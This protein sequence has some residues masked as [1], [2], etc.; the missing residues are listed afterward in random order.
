MAEQKIH[1][2]IPILSSQEPSSMRMIMTL[3]VAGFFSGLI[4]VC[5][6]VFTLP[7]IERNKEEALKE[8]IYRVLP[9]CKKYD[10]MILAGGEL[11]KQE[12]ASDRSVER[13]FL[14]YNEAGS[15]IGFAIPASEPGFA[16]V[17]RL[18]YGFNGTGKVIIGYEILDSKE[19]PGLGD[20]IFKDKHFVSNFTA[21]A[22]DPDIEATKT[23]AKTKPNQVETITG[24]TI[25]S[26]AV[27]RA[28]QKS[29]TKWRAAIDVYVERNK[30]TYNSKP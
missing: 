7:I 14:G 23:G 9:G 21:L 2:E 1:T 27:I 28:L 18:I 30:L 25:S 5:A 10:A 8:A 26:K 29:I 17:I 6:Y 4:L 16:D 3:A 13:I 15:V 19:T 11:K 22:V 12:N 20:K 24:A